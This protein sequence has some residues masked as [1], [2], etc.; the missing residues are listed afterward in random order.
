MRTEVIQWTEYRLR[1]AAGYHWLI[2]VTQSGANYEAPMPVNAVGAEICQDLIQ[3]KTV[4]EIAGTLAEKYRVSLEEMRQD[5]QAFMEQ[6][7]E[8]IGK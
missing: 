6:V 7:R 3:G 8:S 1:E 2:H 5:V 4:E